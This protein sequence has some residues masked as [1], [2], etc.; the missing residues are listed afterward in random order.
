MRVYLR[1]MLTLREHHLSSRLQWSS[2]S[3]PTRSSDAVGYRNSAWVSNFSSKDSW[4]GTSLCRSYQITIIPNTNALITK[5][6][7]LTA[8]PG[9]LL[10][11]ELWLRS[12]TPNSN[13]GGCYYKRKTC[14]NTHV[15][16]K[17]FLWLTCSVCSRLWSLALSVIRY[18]VS[19]LQRFSELS[20]QPRRTESPRSYLAKEN[21]KKELKIK[22]QYQLYPNMPLCPLLHLAY[23][24]NLFS[25]VCYSRIVLS[26]SLDSH[27][28]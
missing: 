16:P 9:V 24:T 12:N 4:E 2:V 21:H 28:F 26:C 5:T 7:G 27:W 8:Q 1:G 14:R 23:Y 11:Q 13:H 10:G 15:L 3:S 17:V 19:D 18:G 25:T 22:I 6:N 20:N